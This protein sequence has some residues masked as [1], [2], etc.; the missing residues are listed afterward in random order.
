VAGGVALMLADVWLLW[1][2]GFCGRHSGRVLGG[3]RP[4]STR[5]F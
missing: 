2:G 3:S 1:V 5:T 4:T